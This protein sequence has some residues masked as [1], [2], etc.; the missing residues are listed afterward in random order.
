MGIA[1]LKGREFSLGDRPGTP[2]VVIINEELARR[3][4]AG[5]D[6]IGRHLL[7]PG[8]ERAAYPA[9][10]VGIVTNSR[11]RTIG[12]PQQASMYEPF[13]Q[14]GNRGRFVHLII[15]TRT[16]PAAAVRG[17]QQVLGQMDPTAAI[18]VQPMQ[19]ALAFAFMPSRI[20]AALLGVLG[21]LGLALAMVGLYAVMAYAV[22]RRTAEIGI[23]V[24]LGASRA[25]VL[26]LVLADAAA[27]AGVGI[28]I[29]LLAAAFVTQPLAMFLVTG[30]SPSDPISFAVTPLVLIAVSLAA[31]WT[32]ARRALRID[33]AL[34]LRQE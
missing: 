27:I 14:R 30:L 19:S 10:I 7:L 8:A 1:L 22:S 34:A 16:D 4:F 5:I 32:P 11:H 15:R 2:A 28:S 9:E 13:L 33:P 20:G 17:V 25:A 29:G 26:R 3:H 12:E 23:R 24:A 6:P 31:A 18:D 21:T